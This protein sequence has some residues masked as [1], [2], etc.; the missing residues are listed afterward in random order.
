MAS[1]PC[2]MFIGRGSADLVGKSSVPRCFGNRQAEVVEQPA[3]ELLALVGL[4]TLQRPFAAS[5]QR[6]VLSS[7]AF[8]LQWAYAYSQ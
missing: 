7:F 6:A 5:S 1:L 4:R 2:G 8:E 3:F